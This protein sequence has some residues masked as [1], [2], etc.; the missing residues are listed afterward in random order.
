MTVREGLLVLADGT[1]FEGERSAP[2]PTAA[3]PPARSCSTRCSRGYQEVHHRPV[4]TPGRSSRS[5]TPTSAT[6]ASTPTTTRA[7]ARSAAAWSSA[8]SPA[9]AVNW[10]ATDDL[11]AFLRRHGVPGIAGIDTR[12]L[13][14]HIRDAGAMPGAFG[15]ADEV[16]AEGG[17]AAPSPAPTASTS[18]PR[19]P[20]PSRTRSLPG[21]GGAAAHRRLRLRHQ[22]HDPAPPVGAR[23][24]RRSCP[25]RPRPTRCSPAVPTA[26]SCRTAPA[27]PRPSRGAAE[28]IA[29]PARPA[30]RC[31]ASASGTSCWPRP[32]APTTYKLP[33][34]HH[35]GNHPVRRLATGRDRDHE[36]EPQ[37]R[38]GRGLARPR[39]RGHPRQPQRRRDRGHPRAD[40]VRAFSVQYHPEAGPGPARRRLPV[41]RVRA[42]IDARDRRG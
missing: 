34:G 10:R 13:T 37:L 5:P 6:T 40:G 33:F 11:D 16:V 22:A 25:R 1:T 4:A 28:A 42:L 35:G 7:A 27:T 3:S 18:S 39:R 2:T 15:S 19:S 30:C 26:C 21:P 9:A 29:R 24:G 20:A 38:G 8:T 14:R 17:G 32:S 36:P 23:D 31:S 12:R 41:R